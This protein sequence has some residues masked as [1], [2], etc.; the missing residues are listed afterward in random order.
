MLRQSPGAG[1]RAVLGSTVT[2]TVARRPEW[3]TTWSESG[4]GAFDSEQIEVTAPQGDWRLVVEVR[5]RYL[6][7]G[8]GSATLSWEGTG[9]GHITVGSVGSDD[10]A[11][12]SGPG[13]Y[14]LHVQ[15]RG[16][17]SWTVRVEQ[18]G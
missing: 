2:L 1:S 8:S 18:L 6:I 12:L 9:A 4:S 11:P 5:P 14:R 16:S 13:T 17:V 15:P 7:F 10:V 3:A